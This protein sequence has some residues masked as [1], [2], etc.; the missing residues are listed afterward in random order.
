MVS[1][2]RCLCRKLPGYSDDSARCGPCLLLEAAKTVLIT[3]KR[4]RKDFNCDVAP[5]A[6]VASAIHF[7]HATRTERGLNLVRAEFGTRR[8]CHACA[9]L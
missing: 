5:K 7:T 3:G 8:K 1:L 9:L 2:G 4:Q 6:R